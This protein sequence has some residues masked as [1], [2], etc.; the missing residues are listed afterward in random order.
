MLKEYSTDLALSDSTMDSFKKRINN[1]VADPEIL[2]FFIS[3]IILPCQ[4]LP[5]TLPTM[6]L[7]CHNL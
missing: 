6:Q 2:S 4:N 1:D 3:R 5:P 7:V